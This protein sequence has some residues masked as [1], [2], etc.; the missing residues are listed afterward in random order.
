MQP[1]Y[2]LPQNIMV[3]LLALRKYVPVTH[4]GMCYG[5]V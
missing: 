5:Q 2:N 1:C 3:V 4:L